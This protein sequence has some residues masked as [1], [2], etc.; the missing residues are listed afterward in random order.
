[1]SSLGCCLSH[2]TFH[3]E[4][5]ATISELFFPLLLQGLGFKGFRVPL[6]LSPLLLVSS[7][8]LSCCRAC[9]PQDPLTAICDRGATAT[10]LNSMIDLT[11]MV[12]ACQSFSSSSR[13]PPLFSSQGLSNCQLD[14]SHAGTYSIIYSVLGS[15]STGAE[16]FATRTIVVQS[17]ACGLGAA[18]GSATQDSLIASMA[19]M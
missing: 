11:W 12:V 5:I 18:M 9:A 14:T 15:A 6:N 16:S 2:C 10:D 19:G 1:M 4:L 17:A 13:S 3:L 8:F 7:S